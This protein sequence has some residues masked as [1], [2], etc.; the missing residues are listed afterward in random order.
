MQQ[1]VSPPR[2]TWQSLV[3]TL[4]LNFGTL[5]IWWVDSHNDELLITKS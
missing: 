4:G 1:S 3:G 5:A 2:H